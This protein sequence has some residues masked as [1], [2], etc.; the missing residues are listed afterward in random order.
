[1][2]VLK[3]RDGLLPRRWWRELIWLDGSTLHVCAALRGHFVKKHHTSKPQCSGQQTA[4]RSLEVCTLSSTIHPG[5]NTQGT[6]ETCFSGIWLF[7]SPHP[8]RETHTLL[9]TFAGSSSHFQAVTVWHLFLLLSVGLMWILQRQPL[10]FYTLDVHPSPKIHFAQN[11]SHTPDT[12]HFRPPMNYTEALRNASGLAFM[13]VQIWAHFLI[14]DWGARGGY[15]CV[16][17]DAVWVL[18]IDDRNEGGVWW[19]LQ[20]AR[21][22]CR[23]LKALKGQNIS[24]KYREASW[25]AALIPAVPLTS[26]DELT[27]LRRAEGFYK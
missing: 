8:T 1:M 12:R 14:N 26:Q 5:Q 24:E 18:N 9:A 27:D 10:W 16:Q 7:L 21:N 15:M 25:R 4:G 23:G 20:E 2:V 6:A 11:L 3:E 17:S 19:S 13:G 22:N